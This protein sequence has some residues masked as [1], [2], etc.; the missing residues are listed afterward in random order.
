MQQINK[1]KAK[2]IGLNVAFIL[3][4]ISI[5]L[6]MFVNKT[7]LFDIL[8]DLMIIGV[9]S[10]V[11]YFFNKKKKDKKSV[12]FGISLLSIFFGISF[13]CNYADIEM[14]PYGVHSTAIVYSLEGIEEDTEN[15]K[16]I[17]SYN[18]EGNSYNKEI[19]TRIGEYKLDDEVKI[20]Y[21]SNNPE[22]A[23]IVSYNSFIM[24]LLFLIFGIGL[25]IVYC[26]FFKKGK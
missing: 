11:L 26:S 18:A 8:S 9:V 22:N 20:V 4:I 7:G 2:K 3:I 25:A 13:L 14:V 21:N 12:V 15:V 10:V 19:I 17:F 23:N 24:G 1:Q 5:I 6:N 16:V